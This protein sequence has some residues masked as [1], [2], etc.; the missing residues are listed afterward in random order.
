MP[1][2]AIQPARTPADLDAARVL[3]QAYASSLDIDLAYQGFTDE[4]AT[5]PG[6][7]APP[8]G[9][10]LLARDPDGKSVGCVAVR[11]LDPDICEMKRLY[12]TP[13]GRGTGLGRTLAN[14][15]I[16]TAT[17]LGYREIRLDTLS[18]MHAA[19]TLYRGLGFVPIAPYYAT[20]ISDTVFLGLQLQPE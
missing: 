18:T 8:A 11:P 12:V 14:A 6:K 15:I 1:Q 16:A 17:N 20:P 7:Y 10:I 3:F 9:D 19:L 5:L 2:F 4:L 13:A